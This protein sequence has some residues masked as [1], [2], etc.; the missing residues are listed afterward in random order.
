MYGAQMG[1][2]KVL[3]KIANGSTTTLWKR[4]LQQGMNWLKGSVVISSKAPFQV[5]NM[6]RKKLPKLN[7]LYSTPLLW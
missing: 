5:Q 2:L 4:S 6:Q 7:H 3:K 1:T